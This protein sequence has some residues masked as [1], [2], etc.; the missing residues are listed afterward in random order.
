MSTDQLDYFQSHKL[1][2]GSHSLH[3]MIGTKS[4][5]SAEQ[6]QTGTGGVDNHPNTTHHG[7]QQVQASRSFGG[8]Y[9]PLDMQ[10]TQEESQQGVPPV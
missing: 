10:E 6:N 7:N 1:A 4:Y 9:R 3:S 8:V 5:Q 2:L